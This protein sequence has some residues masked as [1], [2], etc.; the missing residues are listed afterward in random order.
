MES[1][2]GHDFSRVRVHIDAPA[3]E[4]AHGLGAAALAF[5]HDIVLGA[6]HEDIDTPAGRWLLA[7]ELAHTVQ[8]EAA[9]DGVAAQPVMSDDAASEQDASRA[10]TTAGSGGLARVQRR[11]GRPAIQRQPE[12]LFAGGSI[13]SPVA[14]EF[15]VQATD[16]MSSVS[17]TPLNA[18][19]IELARTIFGDSI[20]YSRVRLLQTVKPLWFRTVGNVIRVPPYFTINPAATV[21]GEDY[22]VEEMRHTFIHELTH[23]WQYQHGGTSYL[24]YALAPQIAAMASGRS[25]NAAYCYE[26]DPAK[27]FWN[28]TPE[29]QGMITENTFM[30]RTSAQA[31]LCGP[32]GE[33]RPQ[34]DPAV[35]DPLR[36]IHER[37]I[38]QLRAALPTPEAAIRLQR[39][40]EVM[41]LPGSD[42]L[43]VPPERQLAPVKPLF[44]YRF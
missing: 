20:D 38:A 29:Q 2:F 22:T 43:P 4:M 33:M 23:V 35:I 37:Y 28:F 9:V 27:S 1:A 19:Q 21:T 12:R 44:E 41:R 26:A 8:Q 5:G 25:R 15:L 13:R 10:A 17:G 24:S 7:H 3:R 11:L 31:L 16:I 34:S 14:E 6:G 42:V 18:M 39:A 36:P 32:D 40:S 30:M